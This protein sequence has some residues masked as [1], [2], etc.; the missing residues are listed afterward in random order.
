MVSERKKDIV[1]SILILFISLIFYMNTTSLR[2]PADI[3]PKVVISLFALL[4][5][6]LLIKA[7][8]LKKE[9]LNQAEDEEEEDN[10]EINVKRKWISIFGLLVYIL[11][12]PIVGFYITS[13]IFVTLLSWY[14]IGMKLEFKATVFPV[15]VSSI[16]M[17]I[18]YA[19][20]SVFLKVPVPSGFLF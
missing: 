1:V 4:G 12:M 19:T 10:V 14:L 13:A 16:V 8:F 3:F 17:G 18:L 2:P 5:T 11:V 7:I 6:F 9:Y 20:F 15:I